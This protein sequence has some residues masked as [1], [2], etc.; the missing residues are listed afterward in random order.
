MSNTEWRLS[1]GIGDVDSLDGFQPQVMTQ[2]IGFPLRPVSGVPFQDSGN[3]FNEEAIAQGNFMQ[4]MNQG[5]EQGKYHVTG[6]VV[7]NGEWTM[8]ANTFTLEYPYPT[9]A[10]NAEFGTEPWTPATQSDE[11]VVY[12]GHTYTFNEDCL[13]KRINV[14]VTQLTPDT[15]YRIIV[16]TQ[17]PGKDPATTVF[18]EPV[19]QVGA[20]KGIYFANQLIPSGTVMLVYIDALNS[21]ADNQ[22]TGGWN[23]EG[24]NNTGAPAVQGWNHNNANTIVRISKTDL[25]GTDRTSELAGI[26]VNTTLQFADTSNP[27]AFNLYRVTSEPPVDQGTYFEYSVVLQEQGEG[28]LPLGTSTLTATIPIPQPTEYAEQVGV[29]PTYSGPNVTVQ[30]FLQF[31]GVDQGGTGNKYGIDLE[32]ESVTSSAD[33]DV[34]SFNT[35]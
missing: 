16:V 19:L 12:S 20:W 11:S 18:E 27:S 1:G 30:G 29:V 28:G 9:P 32:L 15:N 23:Y 33:W 21:G 31:D 6:S 10:D 17:A 3:I 5:W 2:G 22:V 26:T 4:F 8:V 35:P 7:T 34:L 13:L 24:Q 25:D 14:W